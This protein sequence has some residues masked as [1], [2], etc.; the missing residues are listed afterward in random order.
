M[1]SSRSFVTAPPI[2]EKTVKVRILKAIYVGGEPREVGDV[3]TIGAGDAQEMQH[4]GR[5]EVI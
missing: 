2:P 1:L 5:V 3:V 4:H